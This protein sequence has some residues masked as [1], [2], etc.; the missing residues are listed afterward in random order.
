MLILKFI[1]ELPRFIMYLFQPSTVVFRI[2][3]KSEF[4]I[5]RFRTLMDW[6]KFNTM[7]PKLVMVHVASSYAEAKA[8]VDYYMG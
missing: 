1:V 5:V 2:E 7:N 4:V 6:E 3:G 8:F